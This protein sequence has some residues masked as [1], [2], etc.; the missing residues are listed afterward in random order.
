MNM[1]EVHPFHEFWLDSGEPKRNHQL[2]FKRSVSAVI[3]TQS[4]TPAH[5]WPK[6]SRDQFEIGEPVL[7]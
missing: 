4:N 5:K 2:H 3:Y 6:N 7:I 1:K